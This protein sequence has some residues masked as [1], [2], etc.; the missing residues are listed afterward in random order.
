MRQ[1]R[2]SRRLDWPSTTPRPHR[3]SAS[4]GTRSFD[5]S[6]RMQFTPFALDVDTCSPSLSSRRFF[7]KGGKA[8]TENAAH[9]THDNERGMD[10]STQKVPQFYPTLRVQLSTGGVTHE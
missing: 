10:G 3:S 9:S 5:S 2:S 8:P 6:M 1:I 4:H 7:P